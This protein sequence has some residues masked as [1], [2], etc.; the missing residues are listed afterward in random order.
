VIA[1]QL[2]I[3]HRAAILQETCEP[4][5]AD[6]LRSQDFRQATLAGASPDL[7]LPEA[8]LRGDV[9]LGEEEIVGRSRVNVRNAPAVADHLHVAAKSR[10][11]D[12]AVH[13]SEGASEQVIE[14]GWLSGD[15]EE[16][17]EEQKGSTNTERHGEAP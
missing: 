7:H 10:D 5:A 11:A 14:L 16:A 9:T 4:I 6:G 1:S 8:I 12:V 15:R 2:L 3:V 13:L 17:G